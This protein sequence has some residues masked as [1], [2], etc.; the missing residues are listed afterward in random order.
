MK[1]EIAKNLKEH[2]F[3]HSTS[4][5]AVEAITQKGFLVWLEDEYVGRYCS[6]GNLGI[7]IYISCNFRITLKFGNTLLRV[8][9]QPGTKILDSSLPPDPEVLEYL[10]REFGRRILTQPPWKVLPRNKK[11]KLTEVVA[12]FRYHYR[13]TWE[14]GKNRVGWSNKGKMHFRLLFDFRKMLIRYGY[15]G[16]GDPED[17]NGIVV[18]SGD[19]ILIEELVAEV[20][21]RCHSE[22]FATDRRQLEAMSIDDFRTMFF[23]K[24]SFKGKKLADRIAA[25]SNSRLSINTT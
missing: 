23:P 9:L 22:M 4:L 11:L 3:Y 13:E 10:Q 12:L 16:Y 21:C 19:R 6:G 20:P 1:E 2:V 14:G 8:S 15:D 24:T 5:E 25:A 7:G 18:F 17:E